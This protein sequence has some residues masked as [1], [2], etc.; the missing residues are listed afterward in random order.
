MLLQEL[1]KLIESKELIQEK[2]MPVDPGLSLEDTL[3]ELEKRMAGARRAIGL[4]NKLENPVQK[5][6]HFSAVT[7]NMNTI[8]A[9]LK[10]A[11]K[12]LDNFERAQTSYEHSS[13]VGLREHAATPADGPFYDSIELT[14]YKGMELPHGVWHKGV[15]Y[16]GNVVFDMI[17]ENPPAALKRAEERLGKMEDIADLQES[18]LGYS[19]SHDMFIMGF[20]GWTEHDMGD[21]EDME[22]GNC[23]PAILFKLSADG[24]QATIE[25]LIEDFSENGEMWYGKHGGLKKAHQKYHDLVDI[26][27]D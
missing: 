20:D 18:Y 5:R 6:K 22:S 4:I 23:S 19:R 26:R 13:D 21:D 27:L 24:K 17:Y 8:R 10:R 25:K 3:V 14:E 9:A 16:H 7:G 12:Q 1:S 15:L 11:M 2:V